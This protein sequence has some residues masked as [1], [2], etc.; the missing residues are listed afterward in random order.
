[1]EHEYHSEWH[2]IWVSATSVQKKY[3]S[4]PLL[5]RILFG[6]W[7]GIKDSIGSGARKY[8]TYYW[9]K[10]VK[11]GETCAECGERPTFFKGKPLF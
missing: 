1:M 4:R 5:Q 9:R 2:R 3:A 10:A 7:L 8:S 6:R 11:N